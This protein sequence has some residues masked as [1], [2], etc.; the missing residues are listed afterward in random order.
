MRISS[1]RRRAAAGSTGTQWKGSR[2]VVPP[3]RAP[4]KALHWQ[5]LEGGE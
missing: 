5:F 3:C 1:Q 2:R 4:A